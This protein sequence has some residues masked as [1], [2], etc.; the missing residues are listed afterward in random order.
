M[1]ALCGG[2]ANIGF[3]CEDSTGSQ[4]LLASELVTGLNTSNKTSYTLTQAAAQLTRD[5]MKWNDSTAANYLGTP[6][7]VTW[8]YATTPD[9]G[10]AQVNPAMMAFV[11]KAIA[12][13]EAVAQIDFTRVGSGTSG[14][15]A[16]SDNAQI[17]IQGQPNYGGGWASWSY[18]GAQ[19]GQAR[20]MTDATVSLGMTAGYVQDDDFGMKLTLHE[21]AHSIGLLHPG[22]YNGS[23]AQSYEANASYFQDSLQYTVMSYWSETK[24]GANFTT[25][26][27]GIK[28]GGSPTG[29]MLHDIAALQRL[30]G[31]NMSTRTGDTVYGFN[32]NTGDSTWTLTDKYDSIIAAVWDA[33]GND[34]LDVSGFN[35]PANIDLREEGFSSFGGL[36]YNFAIAKGAII[37]NAIGGSGDDTIMGN[38]AGNVLTG[39]GGNDV[40]Y[41]MEGNDTLYGNAGND[42]LMGGLGRDQLFGGDGDDWIYYDANDAWDTNGVNGGKGFDTLVFETLWVAIDLVANG[43]EQSA[44]LLIDTATEIWKEISQFYNIAGQMVQKETIFDDGT[45]QVVVYDVANTQSWSEWVRTYDA[46]GK[47]TSETFIDNKVAPGAVDDNVKTNEDATAAITGNVLSNDSGTNVVVDKVENVSF[48]NTASQTVTGVYGTLTISTNG[49]W[50]YLLDTTKSAFMTLAAGQQVIEDFSYVAKNAYGSSNAKIVITIEGRDEPSPPVLA[51]DSA[52]VTEDSGIAAAGNVLANDS[53]SPLSVGKVNATNVAAT[54]LTAIA[55]LYGTLLI[56][57]DG[58][59]SYKLNDAL[60]AVDGLKN[61]EHLQDVFTYQVTNQYGTDTDTLT[62]DIRGVTDAPRTIMGTSASESLT[63]S[64]TVDTIWGGSGNDTIDGRDGNDTLYGEAG[65]DL[66]RGGDGN[67]HV[68]GGYGIDTLYGDAGDDYIDVGTGKSKLAYGG[69]GNDTILGNTGADKLYGDAGD[70]YIDV[71]GGKSNLAYGDDGNDT[72]LGGSGADTLFGGAGNDH[73]EAGG[74]K[75]NKLYG[76]DGHDTLIGGAGSDTLYGDAGNDV[77]YAGG[78]KSD[79]LYGGD[80]RDIL[81][82][83]TGSDKFYGGADADLFV[84]TGKGGKDVVYDYVDGVDKLSLEDTGLT[85][86]DLVIS[87]SKGSAIIKAIDG[88]M[89]VTILNAAGL[90][91]HNDFVDVNDFLV[92]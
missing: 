80:G 40:L 6:G 63:G 46:N 67:D 50:S 49:N 58:S 28:V 75:S 4:E 74:G 8:A 2:G 71:G 55:G 85:F 57:A 41:G 69:D 65:N 91:D 88:S 7:T 53:G 25:W 24:T 83:G 76:G 30:Y 5:N 36:K 34:T 56:A 3:A 10:Y 81:Y 84:F 19:S 64:S 48:G 60:D 79:A 9:N 43:F 66:L 82:G 21:I 37:E 12:A 90:I 54:G 17:S 89:S 59:Y 68:F 1:C 33:G 45:S 18:Y 26:I 35:L 72:I 61:G 23:S 51:H 70:D 29:L 14:P 47:Q 20:E 27:D 44:L 22:D 87:A 39:N 38:A 42:S 78:G 15:G 31:A 86:D 52:S 11:D 13:I 77:L 73:L 16:Y 62:I 92:A 32:S